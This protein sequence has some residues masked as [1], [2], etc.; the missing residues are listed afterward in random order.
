MLSKS[1]GLD[2]G[3][4][5][6]NVLFFRIRFQ[7]FLELPFADKM[8]LLADW[9]EYCSDEGRNLQRFRTLTSEYRETYLSPESPAMATP[10]TITGY[11]CQAIT[12]Y[13][14]TELAQSGHWRVMAMNN[15]LPRWPALIMATL[16]Q[17][18][19]H[20]P[21]AWIQRHP[22]EGRI[23][24]ITTAMYADHLTSCTYLQDDGHHLALTCRMM[25]IIW[26]V[27]CCLS[28]VK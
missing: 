17:L 25:V 24:Q 5:N 26:P 2:S 1:R 22:L 27:N 20:T 28:L 6:A 4:V 10:S 18:M 16:Q 19:A 14:L 23:I 7:Y 21:L 8:T 9:I 11:V 15:H 12:I 3:Q 13:Q